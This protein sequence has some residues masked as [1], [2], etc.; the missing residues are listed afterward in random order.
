MG[1]HIIT[2]SKSEDCLLELISHFHPE[3]SKTMDV[4]VGSDNFLTIDEDVWNSFPEQQRHKIYWYAGAF[5]AGYEYR[6]N[7]KFR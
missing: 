4:R 3:E 1:V 2:C 7:S 5:V 6:E